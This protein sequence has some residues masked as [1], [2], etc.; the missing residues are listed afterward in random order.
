MNETLANYHHD[1]TYHAEMDLALTY[2]LRR[3]ELA[4]ACATKAAIAAVHLARP[5]LRHAANELLAAINL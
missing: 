5:D 4:R 3:P 2:A 1:L